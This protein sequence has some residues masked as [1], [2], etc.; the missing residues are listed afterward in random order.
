MGYARKK[1]EPFRA[2]QIWEFFSMSVSQA[3]LPVAGSVDQL[4][5]CFAEKVDVKDEKAEQT[6]A[7]RVGI[8][9]G[10]KDSDS[11]KAV[12]RL[13][14][15]PN[16]IG[17]IG[18]FACSTTP[19]YSSFCQV[20]KVFNTCSF[21][22][23]SVNKIFN[24][25]KPNIFYGNSALTHACYKRSILLD[26]HEHATLHKEI[27]R[28]FCKIKTKAKSTD[29]IPFSK[30]YADKNVRKKLLQLAR[31]LSVGKLTL[32]PKVIPEQLLK[33]ALLWLNNLANCQRVVRLTC[34]GRIQKSITSWQ[35]EYPDV[36]RT[37]E[38][39]DQVR[40]KFPCI[41]TIEFYGHKAKDD[42][43]TSL[44]RFP[45]VDLKLQ[46]FGDPLQP[47]HFKAIANIPTLQKL[48]LRAESGHH[49]ISSLVTLRNLTSIDFGSNWLEN[50]NLQYFSKFPSLREL[51][52]F[53]NTRI[54]NEGFKHLGTIRGLTALT[55]TRDC[56]IS[57][58]NPITDNGIL[59]LRNLK[60]VKLNLTGCQQV[61]G[62]FL[63]GL[64]L[65][66]L[67]ELNLQDTGINDERLQPL[68]K[69]TNLTYLNLSECGVT[70]KGLQVLAPLKKLSKL[71]T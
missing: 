28:W 47:A 57:S 1:S 29:S 59:F 27:L 54:T 22:F 68:A 30:F 32:T 5:A 50:H 14:H 67:E 53:N 49:L 37:S 4:A 62:A 64:R 18:S 20:A 39:I 15:R 9:S 33:D 52:I 48:S 51:S 13:L 7:S 56:N 69:A 45:L 16:L 60:L 46:D 55:F 26:R 35:F 58:K 34:K 40:S 2:I 21:I 36:Y 11:P 12:V 44:T 24:S 19:E 38:S 23:D 43:L 63:S 10:H 25:A 6:P 66:C 70:E 71:V 17:H 65:D 41:K 31:A 3:L 42:I 61:Y 8:D